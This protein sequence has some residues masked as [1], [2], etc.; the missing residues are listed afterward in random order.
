MAVPLCYEMWSCCFSNLVDYSVHLSP[1]TFPDI[2]VESA[3]KVQ[4][5]LLKQ[6]KMNSPLGKHPDNSIF[7]RMGSEPLRHI[8]YDTITSSGACR[9]LWHCRDSTHP[10]YSSTSRYIIPLLAEM[11]R[12]YILLFI[13]QWSLHIRASCIAHTRYGATHV[14]WAMFKQQQEQQRMNLYPRTGVS[15]SKNQPTTKAIIAAAAVHQFMFRQALAE[16]CC[17]C[18]CSCCSCRSSALQH[19]KGTE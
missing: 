12:R 18:R 6:S 5:A 1:I 9:Y 14:L 4:L 16:C 10:W 2:L 11:W 17:C 8:R 13:L 15:Y 7:L 3:W 19:K